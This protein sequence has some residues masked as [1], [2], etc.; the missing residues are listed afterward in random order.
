MSL[1]VKEAVSALSQKFLLQE[2]ITGV[3]HASEHLIIYVE[4]EEDR[5]RIPP[6]I[7]G[8]PV[9]V[10]V[11]GKI[12]ALAFQELPEAKM[13]RNLAGTMASR[14]SRWRPIPGGVSIGSV[15]ISAGTLTMAVRDLSTGERLGLSNRHVFWG[16]HGTSVVQPGIYDGGRDPE[17]V[18][19][20]IIRYAEFISPPDSNQIDAALMKP[21]NPDMLSDEILDIGVVTEIEEPTVGMRVAKSG[22]TTGYREA[23][24]TDVNASVKVEGYPQLGT[25]IF[26]N[27][28]ITTKLL[29]GGDSGSLIINTASRRAVGLGFAGSESISV[30]NKMSVVSRTLGFSLP[31]TVP[32]P[33][34][35]RLP[36]WIILLAGAMGA[37][38]IIVASK[39]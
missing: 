30:F 19:G 24:V 32:P 8:Y 1:S 23:T 18:V 12:K 39:H 33:T 31:T 26:E 22:R 29:E 37:I 20:S 17:D 7:M 6:T 11:T 2:G 15:N 16:K 27:Q 36:W 3:S 34:P 28:A 4:E 25:L 35:S 5:E 13:G 21:T 9:E 14:S 38:I 10:R